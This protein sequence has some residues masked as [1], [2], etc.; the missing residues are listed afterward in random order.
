[1]R[2][3][4]EAAI[5]MTANGTVRHNEGFNTPAKPGTGH[6]TAKLNDH[7][8]L[9]EASPVVTPWHGG[10]AGQ[11]SE[12]SAAVHAT[13]TIDSDEEL[14]H[15]YTWDAAGAAVDSGFSLVLLHVSV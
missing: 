7:V 14:V 13:V 2:V 10:G 12:S 5:G 1:M 15:I 11:S 3:H 9:A 6:Y 8:G 4:F